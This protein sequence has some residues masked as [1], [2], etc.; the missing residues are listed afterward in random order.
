[1]EFEQFDNP[2]KN[3][4]QGKVRT[5]PKG[6]PM[7]MNAMVDIAFLLL[8]F[9]MLTTTMVKPKAIEMVMPAKEQEEKQPL[10]QEIRESRALTLIALPDNKLV[11]YRGFSEAKAEEITYGKEGIRQMLEQFAK[12]IEEP[13]VLLKPH[14]DS[15]FENLVDLLDEITIS[16]IARY[17]IDVFGD[18]DK[19]ILED[20]GIAVP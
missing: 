4:R 3:A 14:P 15:V 2:L 10:T 9:F 1:M 17:T 5:P 8:T 12:E 11:F 6:I 16:G 18:R 13:V 20:S 7:D 19:K